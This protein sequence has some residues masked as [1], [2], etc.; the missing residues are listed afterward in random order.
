MKKIH[1]R[2]HIHDYE[3]FIGAEAVERIHHKARNLRDLHLV[4]VNSTYYGGGVAQLL[5]SLTLLFNSVDGIEESSEI[6]IV[7][8]TGSLDYLEQFLD[9]H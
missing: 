5:S 6:V 1:K 3:Q 2:K 7:G 4:S 9:R 8:F